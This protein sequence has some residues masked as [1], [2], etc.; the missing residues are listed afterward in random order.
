MRAS[1]NWPPRDYFLAPEAMAISAHRGFRARWGLHTIKS[2]LC[3]LA[4]FVGAAF[5][6]LS[7]AGRTVAVL[8]RSSAF[9]TYEAGWDSRA[10][11]ILRVPADLCGR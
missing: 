7:V 8:A 6:G 11:V 4:A 3:F 2:L 10:S 1:V 5:N 9:A